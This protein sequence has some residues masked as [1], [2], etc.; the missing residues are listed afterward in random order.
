[1][2]NDNTLVKAWLHFLCND[3]NLPKST[4]AETI[5][6]TGISIH[7][8]DPYTAN[9]MGI[10]FFD[11]I[12]QQLLSFLREVSLSG[13]KRVLAIA[14][15]GSTLTN[16]VVWRLLQAGASDV[17]SWDHSANPEIEIK[18]R[19]ERW[20]TV[21]QL[22]CSSL[23]RNNLVG[24]SPVWVS[25]LRQIIEVAKF[26]D[27]NILIMGETGT[28]K[29]LI[30]R[31]IHTLDQRSQKH[32]LVVL[33][34]TTIVSELSGSEFFGHERGAFTGAVS[35]RDGAFALA[36]D[37]TLF[38]DEVGELPL[39]LQAQLLRVVQE[40]TYK[41]V[42]GNAW[43][44]TN[45]RL[46]CATNKNLMQE[47]KQNNFRHDFYYR[48]AN[49]TCRLPPL[50]ERSEDIMPLVQHFMKILRTDEDP[51]ELDEPVREYLIKRDYPGNVRD[52]RQLVTRLT[53]RHIGTG[54]ITA[55]DIPEEDRLSPESLQEDWCNKHFEYAIRHALSAG[56]GLKEIGRAAE[57]TAVRIAVSNEKGNLQRAARK[58][59]VTDRALQ[60]RRASRRQ[61]EIPQE[62]D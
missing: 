48:I 30:A 46:V 43:Q 53:Y 61:N 2:A 11:D 5:T 34:C 13:R 35:S 58:L 9:D 59:G 57:E 33:D 1:M 22:A 3:D 40:H 38:L 54:P 60:L 32:E 42:G 51:P 25:I 24:Q 19:L 17:F 23:V 7:T 12:N 50:R 37:G 44:S 18:N 55:G 29:E 10:V 26:T 47:V 8:S 14:D 16:G 62:F 15:S 36:N 52:L 20:H 39:G 49:W 31:L 56:I 45:F 27:A 6:N 41:R 4:V 28:G 21:D